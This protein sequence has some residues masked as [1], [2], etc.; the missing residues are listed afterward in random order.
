[1]KL[2]PN[3]NTDTAKPAAGVQQQ[4]AATQSAPTNSFDANGANRSCN[5]KVA[6]H[7]TP[8]GGNGVHNQQNS[9][10]AP[11]QQAQRNGNGSAQINQQPRNNGGYAY[12]GQPNGRPQQN[13]QYRV[14]DK[15]I[16]DFG[17]LD[18]AMGQKQQFVTTKL[19]GFLDQ[20]AKSQ[21]QTGAKLDV[22]WDGELGA[23]Y[24][25]L[26]KAHVMWM[27]GM[28]NPNSP[29]Y[30]L[31]TRYGTWHG[32]EY[33][34]SKLTQFAMQNFNQQRD[35]NG[36]PLNDAYIVIYDD[37][38]E[39]NFIGVAYLITKAAFPEL[40]PRVTE[41]QFLNR[42]NGF[43]IVDTNELKLY[44]TNPQYIKEVE[45][46]IR[47]FIDS[48]SASAIKN[49][50]DKYIAISVTDTSNQW[51]NYGGGFNAGGWGQQ[52]WGG[53][54]GFGSAFG[55][56]GGFGVSGY[57]QPRT[58]YIA[59]MKYYVTQEPNQMTGAKVQVIH[60]T[61]L[62][63]LASVVVENWIKYILVKLNA[64]GFFI[65]LELD[66]GKLTQ[67]MRENVMKYFAP[68]SGFGGSTYRALTTYVN[69]SGGSKL[70]R[71][72]PSFLTLP[73]FK[74]MYPEYEK[75]SKFPKDLNTPDNRRL[76][77]EYKRKEGFVQ[78]LN[79]GTFGLYFDS[80][81]AYS[82]QSDYEGHQ[83]AA[84][85]NMTFDEAIE[86]QNRGNNGQQNQ[87]QF[88]G[89]QGWGP[90]QP[91]W[92]GQPGWNQNGFGGNRGG[93]NGGNRGFNQWGGNQQ[94]GQPYHFGPQ[95]QYGFGGQPN[96]GPQPW[97]QPQWGGQPGFGM[98]SPIG[99]PMGTQPF[100]VQ[101]GQPKNGKGQPQTAN[102]Y[103][104][105]PVMGG[106]M[107]PQF[108]GMNYGYGPGPMGFPQGNAMGGMPYQPGAVAGGAFP[109]NSAGGYIPN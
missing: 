48:N 94:W 100:P 47:E 42:R 21:A 105:A 106:G 74:A 1:M 23:Y 83:W 29:G 4:T 66:I 59:A 103:M 7:I 86:Q 44:Q 91:Q 16:L 81:A 102:P 5:A 18:N 10:S 53:G 30:I 57:Q 35:E 55:Q 96:Y 76:F 56:N 17:L 69:R 3:N 107:G 46:Q 27:T 70:V 67:N 71:I 80:R 101:Q 38:I 31:P 40:S 20:F 98:G 36:N 90:Q 8:L 108:G 109:G 65:Q 32:F 61:E 77:E 73:V 62:C 11:R 87:N 13:Q 52:Q 93:W 60:I 78:Y 28:A 19:G 6:V 39:Y 33:N 25:H 75:D 54:L 85:M 95:P 41:D 88:G 89:N 37:D 92:G 22:T 64:M 26:G 63:E 79:A 99:A 12:G 97:G 82:I 104:G 51:V 9:G 43:N 14:N 15:L 49:A 24:I 2:P 84:S 50:G 45:S 58:K 34:G 72:S 68:S